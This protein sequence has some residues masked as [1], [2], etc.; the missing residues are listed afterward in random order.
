MLYV[1]R[2]GCQWRQLPLDFRKWKSDYTVFRR[3]RMA[4]VWEQIHNV[5]RQ[6]VRRRPL[7]VSGGGPQLNQFLADASIRIAADPVPE[8][9][10]WLLLGLGSALALAY[11]RRRKPTTA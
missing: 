7:S 10:S 2:T 6:R 8:P 1:V 4:G 9:A 5:L 3:W 11:R